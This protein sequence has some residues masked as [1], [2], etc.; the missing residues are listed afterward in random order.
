M[1]KIIT[2]I[3]ALLCC[4]NNSYAT[5]KID[6][7]RGNVAPLPVAVDT[8]KVS[9]SMSTSKISHDIYKVIHDDLENC[10]LFRLISPAA[11]MQ[12]LNVDSTPSYSSWR[13]LDANAVVGG[14]ITIDSGAIQI[15]FKIWDPY[16][17][18]L[19]DGMSYRAEAKQWRR[20]AH[21]V[22]D[23]IYERMTGE[24]GMFD[25]RVLYIAESGKHTKRIKK[26]AIM[27]QDGANQKFLTD[28]RDMCLTPRF[29]FNSHRAIY[30]SYKSRVPQV[31]MLD[32]ATGKQELLGRFPG[33]SFA[34]RFSPDGQYAIMS[35]AKG[36][37]TNIVLLDLRTKR[38]QR[39]TH[40]VGVINTSPSFSPDGSKITFNSDRGGSMQLYV[41]D[42]DGSNISRISHEGG[43][44]STPVWSPRGDY[45]A[46]T[47]LH[48]NMFY[49]GVM[50]PD[51]SG[52]RTLTSSWLEEGPTW[53]PNGRVIMFSRQVGMGSRARNEIYAVD[54]TGYHERRIAT[55]TESSDPAW[56]PLLP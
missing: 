29:D 22:A 17:E 12:Q 8:F 2:I 19:V 46:F 5:L 51:G 31:Y 53:A 7:T 13:Q 14:S 50:R 56:S 30:M 23:R 11:F 32:I 42:R 43:S 34:P 6:I 49:T 37:S 18:K 45:I 47:K 39:L 1:K 21:K 48:H 3:A 44:Y 27:D 36:G 16:S 28:G 26:L 38:L 24:K 25:T 55:T 9:G 10:G 33:M 41:M 40:D 52:E 15:D 54:L 20:I 4:I 35:I